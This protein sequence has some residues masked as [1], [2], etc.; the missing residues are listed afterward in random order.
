MCGLVPLNKALPGAS[1]LSLSLPLLYTG[2]H[3]RRILDL[4][5][6]VDE[7]LHKDVRSLSCTER[8]SKSTAS[9]SKPAVGQMSFMLPQGATLQEDCGN[10]TVQKK[11]ATRTD[12]ITACGENCGKN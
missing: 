4:H 6:A 1:W 5:Q 8:C 7:E 10:G 11:R 12:F 2:G 3:P 9:G